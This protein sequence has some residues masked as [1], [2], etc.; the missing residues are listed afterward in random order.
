MQNKRQQES[1]SETFSQ[2]TASLRDEFK[3]R[4]PTRTGSLLI[5]VFGDAIAP[6]GGTVWLGSLISALEPFGINQRAV[7]TS[8]FRL[9]K[10]GWMSGEQIGRRSYYKL[11]ADGR[12][13]FEAASRRIYSEPRHDWPGTWCLVLLAGVEAPL[14]ET[15]RKELGWL[16]FA[17]FSANLMAHPAP[18]MQVVDEQIQRL[19]GN[20][21]LLVMQARVFD[22]HKAHLANLVHDAW[23]LEQLAD[24]Y[25]EFLSRFRPVYQAVRR[26][27]GVDPEAAFQVRTLL[28][29][30]YRKVLLRDPMLPEALLPAHW[31]GVA[32][33]QLCRNIYGL[34]AAPAETFLMQQ[35]ETA[36]GPL[37]PAEPKFSQRFDSVAQF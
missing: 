26:A 30:E 33:Y 21:R 8:V 11:T 14:R 1:K 10:D 18:D 23:S 22:K 25:S 28:I 19:P 3:K 36:D 31:D 7:R 32:A 24:L 12:A 6:H 5:S 35:M 29:H 20:D 17:P 9:T 34:V 37:P 16:G 13:R 27:R 4:Q 2:A 15:L